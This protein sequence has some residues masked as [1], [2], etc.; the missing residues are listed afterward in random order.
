VKKLK[1]NWYLLDQH[2]DE[3]DNWLKKQKKSDNS[4]IH[5]RIMSENIDFKKYC[6]SID[7]KNIKN[8]SKNT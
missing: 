3:S 8:I 4:I 7:E 5:G 6:K 2:S 1:P